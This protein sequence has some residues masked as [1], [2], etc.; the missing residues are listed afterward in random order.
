MSTETGRR[1]PDDEAADHALHEFPLG[2]EVVCLDT[3]TD[4]LR[5]ANPVGAIVW[6]HWARGATVAATVDAL[7]ER[8]D[9]ERARLEEDV[10]ETV[11]ALERGGELAIR[12]TAD[13]E[14]ILDAVPVRALSPTRTSRLL[15]PGVSV[16]LRV[17]DDGIGRALEDLFPMTIDGESSEHFDVDI[18]SER[19][20]YPIVHDGRTL[21]T[22]LT[23]SDAAIKGMRE[24]SA[25]AIQRRGAWLAV[26]HASAVAKGGRAVLFPAVG[27]SG[28]TTLAAWLAAS[29]HGYGLLN[30]DAVPLLAGDG[31]LRTVPSALSVKPGSVA[32]LSPS[33]PSIERLPSHRS[34]DK[35]IR[36]V[37]V[38]D[39]CACLV[40]PRCALVALPT[41][42]P[43]GEEAVTLEDVSP[44]VALRHLIESGCTMQRPL[45]PGHVRDLL[46]WLAGTRCVR[47]TYRDLDAVRELLDDRLAGDLIS[48][49]ADPG[50]R[51]GGGA[52]ET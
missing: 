22:G 26:F 4:R 28:K 21:D 41:W 42:N 31:T 29:G 13:Y 36:H 49:T 3:R 24:I 20:R 46:G 40:D 35:V 48:P 15:L 11:G 39:E 33:W 44:T 23:P 50:A 52:R 6:R 38:P 12:P 5:I 9:V 16:R 34:G 2:D 32:A 25:L 37:P 47:L 17:E 10:R 14:P 18:Y 8:F 19:G 1:R 30:D 7:E 45:R 43:H 27:G 51:R